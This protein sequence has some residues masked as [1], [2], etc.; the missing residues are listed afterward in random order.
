MKKSRY[1]KIRNKL[2][3]LKRKFVSFLKSSN[4]TYL[5]ILYILIAF[6]PIFLFIF[7]NCKTTDVDTSLGRFNSSQVLQESPMYERGQIIEIDPTTNEEKGDRLL[8]AG[9]RYKTK[10]P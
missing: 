10:I 2:K 5:N 8:P 1:A 4:P 7:Q 3:K 9:Y 6:I